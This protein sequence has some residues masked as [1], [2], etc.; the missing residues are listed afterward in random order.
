MQIDRSNYEI[1]F[2]D[3]LDG[4]LN[5][6]QTGQLKL[7]LNENP[8]L[9]EELEDFTPVNLVPYGILFPDKLILQKSVE[10]IPISQFEY[11]CAAYH[12]NDLSESQRTELREI[13]DTY[14][15]KRKTFNLIQKTRL[16]SPGISYKH[17]KHLL[18]RTVFQ[19]VIR[20][21]V[22]GLSAAAAITLIIISYPVLSGNSFLKSNRSAQNQV[23]ERVSQSPA[24]VIPT[25]RKIIDSMTGSSEQI[26]EGRIANIPKEDPV[27]TNSDYKKALS[28]DSMVRK[29]DDQAITVK[30][31]PVF[32]Q[33]DL[34]KGIISNTLVAS[35]TTIYIPEVEDE[36]SK[37]GRFI[38]K[39]FREKLLKEKTPPDS[40][41]KGYEIA[42][43]G[44]TGLN[45]L[46]GWEMALDKKNDQN[47]ELKSVY[48]SSKIL[49]FNAP[50]KKSEP[51]P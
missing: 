8:D 33:I 16:A 47:G 40:P 9:R 32:T 29:I 20:L 35:N 36:R 17:K 22:I 39:T 28:D 13:I 1:W 5:S 4:N 45:K 7:F 46:F 27:I 6:I 25:D 23:S 26:K 3:W 50:V 48:F 15:D 21:S 31:V 19:K 24:S 43:A 34:E 2:I 11:L 44:V 41:L 51:L 30:K 18:K 14:P 10:E 38:A 49:K 42:E 12:E 37:V